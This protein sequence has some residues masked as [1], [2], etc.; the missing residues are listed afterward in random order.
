ML[1]SS[2]KAL[3]LNFILLCN[4]IIQT[5]ENEL[6]EVDFKKIRG[7]IIF[8]YYQGFTPRGEI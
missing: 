1:F 7:G 6:V 2:K 3:L 4:N 8:R 5:S